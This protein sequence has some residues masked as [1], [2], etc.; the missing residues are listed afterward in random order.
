MLVDLRSDTVTRP[1]RAMTEAM[2]AAPVG[3]DVFGE[4]PTI[5]ELEKK[6]AAIFGMEDSIFCPSG[7]MSNQIA[8]QILTKPRDE[9]ICDHTSHVYLY[10][11]AGL[12]FNSG[13]S[14]CL[15]AGNRGRITASQ[16]EEN[17]R[18]DNIHYPKTSAV[19]LENTHNRGGGSI[20]ELREIAAIKEVCNKNGLKLHLD[21]ARIFN[22]LAAADYNA[23]DIG[24]YF[25]TISVSIS[26]GL[27]APVGSLLVGSATLIK[28]ARR[29]RKV[30]GGGM[31]QAGILAAA[32]IYAIDNNMA[33][34]KIDH[35]RAKTLASA[36]ESLP[37]TDHVL[38]VDTNIVITFL[39]DRIPVQQLLNMLEEKNIRTVQFGKQS[40]RMVTHL[41][42]TDE[43]LD[44]TCKEI[45]KIKNLN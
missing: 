14:T 26:K 32:G 30:F 25:D 22:A 4:D 18:P 36:M 17:I 34:L 24:K 3:D 44:Y 37:Y 7:T 31:R 9:I 33:G 16:V 29:V 23:V 19:S 38:P 13:L 1:S 6:V 20:Y 10:E 40:I 39:N 35:Q 41:D 27:G 2:L 5:N 28:D 8:L 11:G 45:N 43:M 42:F 12:A 15:V 21:G